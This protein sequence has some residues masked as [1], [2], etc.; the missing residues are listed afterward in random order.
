MFPSAFFNILKEASIVQKQ[1]IPQK[2]GL[3][4]SFLQLKNLRA[5][6]YQETY[7]QQ[8]EKKVNLTEQIQDEKKIKCANLILI[9]CANYMPIAFALQQCSLWVFTKLP[10]LM[11]YQFFLNLAC[12]KAHVL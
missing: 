3:I 10:N 2:K 12:G 5:W 1:I 8:I 11:Y 4:L 7:L 6:H 9:L